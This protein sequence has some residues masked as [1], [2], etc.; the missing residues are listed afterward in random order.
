MY[1]FCMYFKGTLAIMEIIANEFCSY[2]TAMGKQ[3]AEAIPKSTR[4]SKLYLGNLANP[5]TMFFTATG[6]R[7]WG[8]A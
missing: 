2:L 6:I 8:D 5:Q 3:F 1:G 4:T 7:L